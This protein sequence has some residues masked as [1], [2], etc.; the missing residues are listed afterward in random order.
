MGERP[1]NKKASGS[2]EGLGSSGNGIPDL[3]ELTESLTNNCQALEMLLKDMGGQ[4][5]HRTEAK[6]L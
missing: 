5:A 2:T 3:V 4:A 6:T 1:V